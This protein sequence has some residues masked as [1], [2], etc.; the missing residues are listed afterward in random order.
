MLRR[1]RWCSTQRCWEKNNK[2][3]SS[4]I[5]NSHVF[6]TS[7]TIL[8]LLIKDGYL[9]VENKLAGKTKTAA[10]QTKNSQKATQAASR[11]AAI[12]KDAVMGVEQSRVAGM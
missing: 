2:A 10:K 9:L 1:R 7:C 8:F 3:N 6:A 11:T 5:T 12:R 4:S